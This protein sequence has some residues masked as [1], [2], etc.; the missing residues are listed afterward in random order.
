MKWSLKRL[1]GVISVISLLGV[2]NFLVW[3][4]E[5]FNVWAL[6]VG[7]VFLIT[8]ILWLGFVIR[9]II[10]ESGWSGRAGS[11]LSALISSLSFL[12]ICIVIYAFVL[13]WDISVDLTKEGR[14]TL[15]PQTVKV[16]ETM[17]KEVKVLCF[18]INTDEE[19]VV[20]AK[21]KTLRFLEQC[22]RHTPFLNVELLDPQI[23]RARLEALSIT[24]ASTQGTVVLKCG[25]RQ[26]VI[27]LSGA[28]PR[29]EERDF[30]QALI[31]VLKETETKIGY[32]TGHDET[33]LDDSNPNGISMARAIIEGE[34]YKIEPFQI[35]IDLPEVPK[36][37]EV[38][39]IHNPK[40]DL[41]REE[42]KAI[43]DFL[44]N[45]GR[46][47]VFFE[48][49]VDVRLGR[50]GVEYLRPWLKEK[51]GVDVGSNIAFTTQ[52]KNPWEIELRSDPKPFENVEEGLFEYRGSFRSDHPITQ[53][54]DQPLLLRAVRTIEPIENLPEN[55]NVVP[56]LR[57]PPE[58]WAETDLSR[59]AEGGAVKY[60]PEEKQ[61]PLFIAVAGTCSKELSDGSKKRSRFV[62]VGDADFITNERISIGGHINFLLNSLAWLTEHDELISIRPSI[63]ED[64]PI[65]LSDMQ[66]RWLIW[67]SVMLTPQL[68][69]IAG[70]IAYFVR[71]RVK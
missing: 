51:L 14:R 56:I 28:N 2:L 53:R 23:D 48:P 33:P 45:G 57:T 55:A 34:S 21:D 64:K 35:R 52:K 16:L 71:R 36:S 11:G 47:I 13:R 42:L 43:Q 22:K 49:W 38:V 5:I 9:G 8:G 24:H 54:M 39:I 41:S 25:N 7:G 60:E 10:V 70:L 59:L 15:S 67:C 68:V 26:R 18:F 69:L 46:L 30:T 62:V 17:N 40:G 63:K 19:S 32:L 6:L 58:Y 3:K 12:G 66:K 44:D 1:C 29:M 20:I 50:S 65:V 31:S 61:G 4:Q 37:Y 27:M